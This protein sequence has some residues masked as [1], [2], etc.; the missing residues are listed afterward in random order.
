MESAPEEHSSQVMPSIQSDPN[1]RNRRTSL[2]SRP[3]SAPAETATGANSVGD[4]SDLQA[5]E[6]E[7]ERD[8]LETFRE[9]EENSMIH[10]LKADLRAEG[11]AGDE[12]TSAAELG[13]TSGGSRSHFANV[14]R[15]S[16]GK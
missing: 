9:S 6:G 15:F 14:I 8:T 2:E 11:S 12:L 7:K 1:F 4:L 13:K 5:K 10:Q 3:D 16:H